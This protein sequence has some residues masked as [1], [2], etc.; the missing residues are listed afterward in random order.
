MSHQPAPGTRP[1]VTYATIY[2]PEPEGRAETFV[3]RELLREYAAGGHSFELSVAI[4]SAHP[5]ALEAAREVLAEFPA[6]PA[7]LLHLETGHAGVRAEEIAF[8][9]EALPHRLMAGEFDYLLFMDADVWTPISQ[10]GAWIGIIGTGRSHRY[11][12]VKYCLRDQFDSPH[13]TLGAYFHHRA[14]LERTRY[15]EHVFPKDEHG[16]RL[17]APDCALHDC[18]ERS[19]CEKIVPD[20]LTSFHFTDPE[21][22][23]IYRNGD[24]FHLLS[25]RSHLASGAARREALD[26]V[27]P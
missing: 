1:R 22:A 26:A 10:V 17:D 5:A 8:C 19:G 7:R 12:K 9:K 18:L 16:R 11:V 2:P 25:A 20:A 15:W 27:K 23:Q 21:N 6:V 4:G 24:L 3:T 13:H 14:L